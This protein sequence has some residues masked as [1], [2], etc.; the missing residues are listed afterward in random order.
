MICSKI[1]SF[2]KFCE[3]IQIEASKRKISD[4]E[5]QIRIQPMSAKD[6]QELHQNIEDAED[7]LSKSQ[8]LQQE[9]GQRVAELQMLHNRYCQWLTGLQVQIVLVDSFCRTVAVV[10][11]ECRHVNDKLRR[12]AA[13]FPDV[14]SLSPL[15]YD[16]TSK[17]ADVDVLQT[18]VECAKKL[19]VNDYVLCNCGINLIV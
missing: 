15:D 8:F 3:E 9:N 18:L 6:A 17:R 2:I 1:I 4:L 11:G 10:D 13:M 7:I 12:L 14:A 5:E 16:C 19:K